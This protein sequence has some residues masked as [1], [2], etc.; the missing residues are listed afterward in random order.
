MDRSW[1]DVIDYCARR[2]VVGVRIMGPREFAP[3]LALAYH[4][5]DR[6]ALEAVDVLI[7]HKGDF[8]SLDP[9]F[10]RQVL[11]SLQIHFANE[12]FL[13]FA[14]GEPEAPVEIGHIGILTEL[15]R[16]IEEGG[17]RDGTV[18][19]LTISPGPRMAATYVG[20]GR[21]LL[22]N[23]FDQLMLVAG[24][25][26]SITPHLVRDG[27][28]DRDLT[29]FLARSLREGCFFIDVGANFGTYSL[30][31]AAIVGPAG[32][33]ISIEANQRIAEMLNENLV[34]N[35]FG[36]RSTV[37]REAAGEAAGV[38]TMFQFSIRQG[39]STLVPTVADLARSS[40]AERISEEEVQC[41]TL[42]AMLADIGLDR[43]DYLKVDV[44][45]FE[46]SVLQG[47]VNTIKKFRPRLIV[48]W[49]PG[50]FREEGDHELHDMLTRRL[51]YTLRVVGPN[52]ST[53]PVSF[54][55]L[56]SL[57]HADIFA[58][59]ERRSVAHD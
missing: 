4:Y 31:A 43:V 32:R 27:W 25:D 56:S 9:E 35:G 3:A 20:Q 17:Y 24:E 47:A 57:S 14:R 18:E 45:G 49:H 33:V 51:G 13:V 42:D 28:F 39:G 50:F 26:T 37:L 1:T 10:L 36:D 48:E 46:A 5:A 12:V 44:E 41:R 6:P 38:R 58:I 19:A 40:Y 16:W 2:A 21:V 52:G 8:D 23:A 7:L 55:E 59:P 30:L 15:K 22:Q 29:R 54:G 34:M 11:A 53:R